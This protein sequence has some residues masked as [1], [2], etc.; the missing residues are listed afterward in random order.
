MNFLPLFCTLYNTQ[1]TQCII[2]S[3]ECYYSGKNKG[4]FLS[5]N[6]KSMSFPS[7]SPSVS[8]SVCSLYIVHVGVL[9]YWNCFTTLFP[10]L[11]FFLLFSVV[12]FFTVA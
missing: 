11:P 10:F 1:Y 9:E 7:P 12:P 5:S 4:P 8:L 3:S 2:K 6:F